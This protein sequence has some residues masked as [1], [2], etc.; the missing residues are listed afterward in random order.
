MSKFAKTGTTSECEEFSVGTVPETD[1][2]WY[3][4]TTEEDA[5]ALLNSAKPFDDD[6]VDVH[7]SSHESGCRHK[8]EHTHV[9]RARVN[10]AQGEYGIEIRECGGA[11]RELI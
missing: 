11:I 4:G 1:V 3:H 5:K 2:W 10:F 7:F 9:V 8:A 6:K